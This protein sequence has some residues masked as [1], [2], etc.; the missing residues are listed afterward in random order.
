MP[1]SKKKRLL[2]STPAY[3][4]HLTREFAAMQTDPGDFTYFAG[5]FSAPAA[6]GYLKIAWDDLRAVFAYKRDLYATD[7][8]CLD[9]F[10]PENNSLTIT[11]ETAGWHTFTEQ[12]A[13]HLPL[14]PGWYGEVA[15]PAFKTKLTLPYERENRSFAQAVA[16][17]YPTDAQPA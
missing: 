7:E 8:L 2:Y 1:D 14:L 16:V 17:Y 4:A 11:E 3:R 15:V 12:L 6:T 13:A 5:G 9:I 10:C